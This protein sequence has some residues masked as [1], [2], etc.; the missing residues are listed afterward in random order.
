MI[1]WSLGNLCGFVVTTTL[2]MTTPFV[3]T[4]TFAMTTTVTRT[5]LALFIFSSVA[6][7]KS[8]FP[9]RDPS[10]LANLGVMGF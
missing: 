1:E 2:V 4:T 3:T 6:D 9:S 10:V 8:N 5:T 7:M